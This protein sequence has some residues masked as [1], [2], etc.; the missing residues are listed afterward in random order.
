MLLG[1]EE[2]TMT[3]WLKKRRVYV[4]P[5]HTDDDPSSFKYKKVLLKKK[6]KA[7]ST[8]YENFSVKTFIGE[9]MKGT[10]EHN[11]ESWDLLMNT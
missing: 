8:C 4:G 5:F 10:E 6:K 3:R 9:C 2:S 7:V 1:E 11:G